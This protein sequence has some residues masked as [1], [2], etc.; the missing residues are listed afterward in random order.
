LRFN[1]QKTRINSKIINLK[2]VMQ[3]SEQKSKVYYLFISSGTLL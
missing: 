2:M 1:F 3:I